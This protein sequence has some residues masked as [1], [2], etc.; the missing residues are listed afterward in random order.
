MRLE[1]GRTLGDWLLLKHLGQGPLG[2]V[3][4]AEHRFTKKKGAVKILPEE[5]S[6]DR[7]FLSRF[8]EEV[9]KISGVDH[10]S[11]T[12]TFNAS[13]ADGL[14]FLSTECVVDGNQETQSLSQFLAGRRATQQEALKVAEQIAGALDYVHGLRGSENGEFAHGNLKPNNIMVA[15]ATPAGPE[16]KIADF[17]LFRM[18]GCGNVLIR[19]YKASI[20][21]LAFQ[22][23]FLTARIGADRYPSSAPETKQYEDLLSSLAQNLYF[24]SPEQR[25]GNWSEPVTADIWAFGVLLFWMLSGGYPEGSWE[26]EGKFG[27]GIVDWESIIRNCLSLDASKRPLRLLPLFHIPKTSPPRP[28]NVE[29]PVP[30][31]IPFIYT[32]NTVMQEGGS[33]RQIKEYAPEKRD[34]KAI[35]PSLSEVAHIPEGI[36]YRGSN[37]GCRDEIPRHPVR[38]ASFIIDVHPVTNEQFVRFLDFLGDE[39]DHQNHD[40]IRLRDSRIKRTAGRFTIERGYGRHPVVGVTWYGAMGYCKWVGKRLPSEAEW[41]VACCGGLEHPTYPT[42]ED[43]E[44]T[45]ANFFSSDTT[46][47]MS[48]PPNEYGIYDMAGNV[49]EWCSDWYEYNYYEYSAQ[50]PD[51]PKGPIQGVYRVLRGGC[52]KSLKEDLRCSKRHRNN[53]GA[54]N[55][56]YGFRCAQDAS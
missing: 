11:I 44:K 5:L 45:Q 31:K 4:F 48:Y 3:Y 32:Q 38:V 30:Q 53:P 35:V 40:I 42:G 7:A 37:Q 47:V 33:D 16:V 17:G 10:P 50:E 23:P 19:S 52:W 49:Y 36:Y 43:I 8:E 15:E 21:Q 34:P 14:Y 6:T 1:E 12:K 46:A 25:L 24:L 26:T 56:T 20:E 28:V 9:I 13:F 2:H 18:I 22:D 55:G 29:V 39:K 41:E 54:A 51:F 27:G